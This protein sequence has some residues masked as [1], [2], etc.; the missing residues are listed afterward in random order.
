MHTPSDAHH[1]KMSAGGSL[2]SMRKEP[3]VT[4]EYYHIYSRG[5]DRRPTY[6][7]DEDCVRF[8]WGMIA[9]NN[10]C[11]QEVRLSRFRNAPKRSRF[12]L[13]QILC[14]AIMPNH[15][16]FLIK[17]LV[18]GGVALFMQRLGA[19]YSCYFN[20][21]NDRTGCLWESEYKAVRI[22]N[23]AQLLHVSRYIHLNPLKLF[24]P[25]WKVHG[26][27]SWNDAHTALMS[28]PW[29]SYQCFLKKQ[30]NEA[31]DAGMLFSMFDDGND[32]CDFLRM[33][34]VPMSAPEARQ[35]S[36]LTRS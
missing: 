16:H 6:N 22:E 12:P 20:R 1:F 18:D 36:T 4:G 28:Y 8:T 5:V 9:F 35:L 32:Y 33:W 26:V 11:K 24:F 10:A 15:Y 7:S 30:S 14:Y 31:I 13:V 25:D 2:F 21:Q 27:P 34:V 23:D 17:Q 3:I 19:G 29:S